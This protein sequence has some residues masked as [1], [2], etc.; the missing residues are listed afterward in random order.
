M[1]DKKMTMFDAVMIC[2]GCSL[3]ETTEDQVMDA[4]QYLVDTGIVWSLQGWFGRTAR[5]LI[6]AG[7]L[8]ARK[9]HLYA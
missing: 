5:N 7:V 4:W 9:E 6:E 1:T 2:E 3:E 8:T